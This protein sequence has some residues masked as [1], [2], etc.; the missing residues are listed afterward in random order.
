VGLAEVLTMGL[1]EP[2][3]IYAVEPGEVAEDRVQAHREMA[4]SGVRREAGLEAGLVSG[5]LLMASE[6]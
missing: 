1:Q 5:A 4:V 3:R 2:L 6:V